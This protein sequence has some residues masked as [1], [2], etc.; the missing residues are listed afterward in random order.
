MSKL[1]RTQLS[2]VS[3]AAIGPAPMSA[4]NPS[5][6]FG[7]R[8]SLVPPLHP[9]HLAT[10]HVAAPFASAFSVHCSSPTSCRCRYC[11]SSNHTLFETEIAT[12]LVLWIRSLACQLVDMQ[13][14]RPITIDI[15]TKN[16]ED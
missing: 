5:R 8:A 7:P 11:F 16:V 15:A 2:A 9:T 6:S 12:R 1:G 10:P 14:S 3:S 13:R 4:R